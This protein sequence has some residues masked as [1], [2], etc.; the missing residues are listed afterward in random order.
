MTVVNSSQAGRTTVSMKCAR[1]FFLAGPWRQR[2]WSTGVKHT[3]C[4]HHPNSQRGSPA[5]LPVGTVADKETLKFGQTDWVKVS[6]Q[7]KVHVS[8]RLESGRQTVPLPAC[9]VGLIDL[10]G[11]ECWHIHTVS[12]GTRLSLTARGQLRSG[13]SDAFVGRRHFCVFPPKVDSSGSSSGVGSSS[14]GS[15]N[16]VGAGHRD[17]VWII[18]LC[19]NSGGESSSVSTDCRSFTGTW[20]VKKLGFNP[21]ASSVC[22]LTHDWRASESIIGSPIGSA[23]NQ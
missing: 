2:H 5:A 20:K 14:V 7:E 21:G 3:A 1:L 19:W 10:K 4:P 16:S 11:N 17:H 8:V 22:F 18:C 23:H 6:Q 12:E 13:Q 9:S 15:S